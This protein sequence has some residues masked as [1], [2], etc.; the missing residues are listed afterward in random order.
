[1]FEYDVAINWHAAVDTGKVE[2]L[3]T[4]LESNGLSVLRCG[5]EAIDDSQHVHVRLIVM[6]REYSR[7][8]LHEAR[9]SEMPLFVVW[10]ESEEPTRETVQDDLL[11]DELIYDNNLNNLFDMV[12]GNVVSASRI[13]KERTALVAVKDKR[14]KTVLITLLT[15]IIIASMGLLIAYFGRIKGTFSSQFY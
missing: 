3:C 5:D 8:Q 6:C 1:M 7:R 13:K 11:F 9:Q 4:F 10:L 12:L 14:E 15:I 2:A